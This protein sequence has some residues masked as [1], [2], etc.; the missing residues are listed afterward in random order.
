[1]PDTSKGALTPLSV[2]TTA[3]YGGS[4][5]GYYVNA[6]PK[7]I[8]AGPEA[9]FGPAQP[10]PAVA[11][12]GTGGR[13]FDYP[14]GANIQY[15]PRGTEPISFAMLRNLADSL[16][17]L[18]LVIE[19][20]KDQ[21]ASWDWQI[22]PE[23]MPGDEVRKP[24][25]MK[26][27]RIRKATKFFRRPDRRH[28]FHTWLRALVEDMLV[29]DAAC[30]YPRKTRGGDL[31]S[32]D[33][34]DG[35]TIDPL[36]DESGRTPLPDDGPAYQQILHGM[37]AA[38]FNLDELLYLPRNVRT[39]K[40]WGY[41]PVEQIIMIVNIALRREVYNLNYYQEGTLP[42]GFATLPKEWTIDQI[43]AFQQYFDDLMS[44]NLA[45]RRKARFVPDGFSFHEV[46][47]PPLKDLYDEWLFKI[48]CYAFS[49]PNTSMT[50]SANRATAETLQLTAND[51]GLVPLKAWA[52]DFFDDIIQREMGYEDLAFYWRGDESLDVLA[53][54][55]ANDFYV[56]N[57]TKSRDEVREELGYEPWG[58]GATTDHMIFPLQ[59]AYDRSEKD[60]KNPNVDPGSGANLVN[61]KPKNRG[62]NSARSA[63]KP[64]STTD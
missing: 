54:A 57:G 29:I 42:D 24:G 58:V 39:N 22:L 50:A 8:S 17:E 63:K 14:W 2:T 34:V 13:Q 21:I 33:F 55:Q 28:S 9:W 35:S 3:S 10:L 31:F 61:R 47:Q 12:P 20:R 26:D 62:A 11:P 25:A 32:I 23:R 38:D 1:M 46:K 64:E 30:I 53:Q 51:E 48:I 45:F 52:K 37:V 16:P 5:G 4:N 44:G 36:L 7:I 27:P 60:L 19:K 59:E 40:R 49:V 6:V 15:V 41:S 56:R 18:R 43:K